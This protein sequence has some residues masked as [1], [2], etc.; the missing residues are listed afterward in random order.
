MPPG[1]GGIFC[2]IKS[3]SGLAQRN[4][5]WAWFKLSA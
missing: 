1:K 2:K 3:T 5:E 4:P